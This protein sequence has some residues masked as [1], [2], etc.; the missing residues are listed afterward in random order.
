M[1]ARDLARVP[2]PEPMAPINKLKQAVGSS[3]AGPSGSALEKPRKP[4]KADDLYVLDRFKDIGKTDDECDAIDFGEVSAQI[5]Q[6]TTQRRA[7][8]RPHS[9]GFTLLLDHCL[10]RP[11]P[12]PF[13]LIVCF[14][15]TPLFADP[16]GAAQGSLSPRF[17]GRGF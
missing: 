14:L 13:T 17:P 5:H 2:T 9:V 1:T 11:R 15:S 7:R 3:S 8:A 4:R 6:K 16:R 10:G 12:S